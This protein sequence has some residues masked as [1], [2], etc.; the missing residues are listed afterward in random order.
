[1]ERCVGGD[2]VQ[3]EER[4]GELIDRLVTVSQRDYS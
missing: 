1:M 4:V 2:H 3:E